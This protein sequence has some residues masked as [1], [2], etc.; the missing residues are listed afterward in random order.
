MGNFFDGYSREFKELENAN[1][2][3]T[4][5]MKENIKL[6]EEMRERKEIREKQGVEMSEDEKLDEIE[7]NKDLVAIAEMFIA[8]FKKHQNLLKKCDEELFKKDDCLFVRH[9]QLLKVWEN[10]LDEKQRYTI[11]SV[12]NGGYLI[13]ELIICTPEKIM[14]KLENMIGEMFDNVV[15]KKMEFDKKKFIDDAKLILRQVDK[16]ATTLMTRY[17]W[18]FITSKFTPIYALVDE[19][20]HYIIKPLLAGVQNERGRDFLMSKISPLVNDVKKRVGPTSIVVDEKTGV[21]KYNDDL[22]SGDPEAEEKRLKERERI[23][24]CI[25]ESIADI[26]S[27]N[28][29]TIDNLF[30]DPSKGFKSLMKEFVPTVMGL[31]GAAGLKSFFGGG[32]GQGGGEEESKEE[33][34]RL[35]KGA[36][37]L[38]KKS[39]PPQ[40][41]SSSSEE[42]KEEKKR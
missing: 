14:Q 18:E 42:S 25:I 29:E 38:L 21:V 6:Y 40:S 33:E 27:R 24:E 39:R 20:H 36:P 26:F 19:E 8:S 35:I 17:F 34:E 31:V 4:L 5:P 3:L 12:L 2:K 13:L 37:T 10:E 28:R 11:W 41:S 23:L 7:D 30:A 1:I 16:E 32:N 9:L 22:P 15:V